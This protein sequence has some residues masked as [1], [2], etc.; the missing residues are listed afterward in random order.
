M[1]AA[2]D[3]LCDP[4]EST[5]SAGELEGG[6]ERQPII[7]RTFLTRPGGIRNVFTTSSTVGNGVVIR[8]RQVNDHYRIPARMKLCTNC[9]WNRRNATSRGPDVSNVAAVITDQSTP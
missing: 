4:V 6:V 1:L 3:E 9:R 8:M 7:E 2:R 5:A